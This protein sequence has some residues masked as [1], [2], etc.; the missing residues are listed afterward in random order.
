MGKRRKRA[1]RKPPKRPALERV[2]ERI[3]K[4]RRQGRSAAEIG[5]YA[6]IVCFHFQLDPRRVALTGPERAALGHVEFDHVKRKERLR[7]A[8]DEAAARVAEWRASLPPPPA[9]LGRE[10]M[11]PT[12][13]RGVLGC[14]ATELNRWA[15]DGR[16]PADGVRHYHLYDAGV[17]GR[18]GRA[19]LPETVHGARAHTDGWRA[20]D[21]SAISRWKSEASHFALV[22]SWY[23]DA[24]RHW[25]PKWLGGHVDVYVPSINVAFEYHGEQHYWPVARFGGEEGFRATQARD[26]R[27]RERLARHG[28]ALV[29]WRFDTPIVDAELERALARINPSASP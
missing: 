27:K 22:L 13:A 14:S 10:G 21:A 28:I 12:E 8:A 5:A 24:R 7:A 16:L 19:W 29:E 1:R 11:S 26:I 6:R 2:T 20:R 18:W 4:R 15:D 25:S 3:Q 23:P 17:R 9:N